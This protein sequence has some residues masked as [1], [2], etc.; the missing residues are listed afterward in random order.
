MNLKKFFGGQL[1]LSPTP[2]PSIFSFK[3]LLYLVGIALGIYI[4]YLAF[5]KP[6]PPTIGKEK[7]TNGGG[8]GCSKKSNTML[9][10]WSPLA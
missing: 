1:G 8:C 10:P 4:L 9:P 6:C 3:N 2:A 7:M 5:L